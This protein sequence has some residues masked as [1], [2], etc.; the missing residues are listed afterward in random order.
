MTT[1]KMMM[2]VMK[3]RMMMTRMLMILLLLM[4]FFS[5]TWSFSEA[6]VFDELNNQVLVSPKKKKPKNSDIISSKRL[7]T[8][9]KSLEEMC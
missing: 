7:S 3:I 4:L 2:M 1:I 8:P 9:S 5:D 6:P